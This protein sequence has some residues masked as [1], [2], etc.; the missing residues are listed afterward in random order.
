MPGRKN[1]TAHKREMEKMGREEMS[2][3]S[4]FLSVR[5][6]WC[7]SPRNAAFLSAGMRAF[8]VKRG[9][10]YGYC[11]YFNVWMLVNEDF[12]LNRKIHARSCKEGG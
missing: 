10:A 5:N 2:L 9:Y 11:R 7:S 1:A 4:Y 6:K 12:F 3:N 8:R